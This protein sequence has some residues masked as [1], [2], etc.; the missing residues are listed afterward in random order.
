MSAATPLG[1]GKSVLTIHDFIADRVAEDARLAPLRSIAEGHVVAE[2]WG[3]GNSCRVCSSF[4]QDCW[5]EVSVPC[6]AVRAI[7]SIWSDHPD[8]ET[9]W[10]LP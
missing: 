3:E 7:A 6:G 10:K 1:F 9:E 2:G 4:C 8:F 5:R